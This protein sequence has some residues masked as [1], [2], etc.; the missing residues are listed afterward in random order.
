LEAGARLAERVKEQGREELAR[1]IQAVAEA[2]LDAM[3]DGAGAAARAGQ[4]AV[5]VLD[6]ASGAVRAMVGGRDYRASPFN[7][8]SQARRQPGSAFKPFIFAAA[9]ER[10]A[11]PEERVADTAL[12]LGGWSPGNGAWRARGEISLEEA[13]VHSVNTS[14][15][16]VLARAGGAREAGALAQRMG[17]A[18][19]FAND[20]TLALGTGEVTLV[21]LVAAY[22]P[23][24]NGGMRVVPHAIAA[25][26]A[27]GQGVALTRPAPERVL[28]PE[29]AA[30]MRRMLEA[31]V[32]RGTG[33]AAALPGRV[34]G[35]KTGTTQEFRDAWFV[36]FVGGFA[37]GV[38]IGVWIGNDDARPMREVR[39]GTLPARLFR[40]IAEALP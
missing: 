32:A 6:A 39:G 23:F 4:G 25:A 13:L 3:L 28:S 36:G 30:A 8:A 9:L 20:A 19:P 26:R 38:V 33:Q 14:A 29:I 27:G 37:G 40:E 1:V 10:G 18:G 12:T 34:A 31:A 16:R 17:L 2:R 22:A 11:T 35:G 24:A 21:D 15:V 7:R 5:V